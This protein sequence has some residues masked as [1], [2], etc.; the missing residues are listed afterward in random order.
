MLIDQPADSPSR[1]SRLPVLFP[2]PE[3]I[4]FLSGTTMDGKPKYVLRLSVLWRAVFV[5]AGVMSL[6]MVADA[7][8]TEDPFTIGTSLAFFGVGGVVMLKVMLRSG[9]SIEFRDDGLLIDSYLT[10]GFI[11]WEDLESAQGLRAFG[12]YY[13]GLATRDPQAYIASRKQL[14]QLQH[15]GDRMLAGGFTRIMM[16]LMDVLPAAKTFINFLISVFGFAPLPKQFDEA[17]FME[18]NHS[19]YGS[20]LLIHKMWL[21]EFDVLL[22]QL[23][24]RVRQMPVAPIFAD[25]PI[26]GDNSPRIDSADAAVP[27]PTLKPCPMCAERVQLQ[28]RICRY[29]R[30]SF[31]EDRLLTADA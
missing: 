24:S 3:P 29:C 14:P 21:P 22:N 4:P 1:G 28:A 19:N 27:A 11:R 10:T 7:L 8:A 5:A 13:L 30:Y 17:N 15:E 26:G 25:D 18:W 31:D 6:S 23:Q 12:V 16:A 20:Q 9:G 2:P